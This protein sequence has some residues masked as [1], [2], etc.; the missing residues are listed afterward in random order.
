MLGWTANDLLGQ[1]VVDAFV[2]VRSMM[3]MNRTVIKNYFK[4]IQTRIRNNGLFACINSFI[5]PVITQSNNTEIS[6]IADY[7]F[8]YLLVAHLFLY[9][10]NSALYAHTYFKKR[11]HQTHIPFK[12]TL[13]TIRQNA[14]LNS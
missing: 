11:E 5:E 2:N 12:E 3:E 14:Y 10:R 6:R 13:K 4:V 1:R 9:I 7:S 8:E